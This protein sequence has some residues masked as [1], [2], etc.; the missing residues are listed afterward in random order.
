MADNFLEA[1]RGDELYSWK[2]GP[3]TIKG[4]DPDSTMPVIG[5]DAESGNLRWTAD[6]RLNPSDENQD[7]FWA[8]PTITAPLPPVRTEKLSLTIAGW[9]VVYNKN[10]YGPFKSRENA[11][12]YISKQTIPT[13]ASP[14]YRSMDWLVV[15]PESTTVLPDDRK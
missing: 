13:P 12:T 5:K 6:G 10:L 8:E 1:R 3:V 14:E 9:W 4:I 2:F 15:V 7:L 11:S